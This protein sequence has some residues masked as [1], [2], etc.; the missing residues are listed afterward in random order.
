MTC[1]FFFFFFQIALTNFYRKK[2]VLNIKT[3]QSKNVTTLNLEADI[4]VLFVY[5]LSF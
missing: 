4:E 3:R 2:Y 5:L 1:T